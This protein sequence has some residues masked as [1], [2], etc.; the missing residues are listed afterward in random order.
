M[1]LLPRYCFCYFAAA[2]TLL[3]AD[4][5]TLASLRHADAAAAFRHT[6]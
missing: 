6:A 2:V 5:A 3:F 4:A 1:L